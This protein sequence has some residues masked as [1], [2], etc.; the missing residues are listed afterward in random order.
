[1]TGEQIK[2][3]AKLSAIS[4]ADEEVEEMKKEFDVILDFV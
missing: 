3:L 1:M 2:Y 4:L